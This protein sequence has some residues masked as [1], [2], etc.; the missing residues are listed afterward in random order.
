M[1]LWQYQMLLVPREQIDEKREFKVEEFNAVTWWNERQPPLD[2]RDQF[3][4]ILPATI[5]PYDDVFWW[6]ANRGDNIEVTTKEN[7]VTGI[8]ARVDCQ[9]FDSA[10][11]LSLFNLSIAWDCVFV[12]RRDFTIL[13]DNRDE[14]VDAILRSPHRRCLVDPAQ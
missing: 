10:F 14:F 5:C 13:P 2:F 4:A 3:A 7:H 12:Y 6:G 8:T 11:S 1:A 9:K